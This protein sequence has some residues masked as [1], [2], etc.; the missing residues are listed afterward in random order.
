V[1]RARIEGEQ[2]KFMVPEIVLTHLMEGIGIALDPNGDRMFVTDL[3]GSIYLAKLDGSDKKTLLEA[4]GNL[5]GIAYCEVP[6]KYV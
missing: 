1:N 5:T 4:Q 2:K 6:T 3:G